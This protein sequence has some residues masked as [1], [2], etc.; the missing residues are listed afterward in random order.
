MIDHLLDF[1]GATLIICG[2]LI[3]AAF[4]GMIVADVIRLVREK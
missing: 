3:A 2:A 4:T 1:F